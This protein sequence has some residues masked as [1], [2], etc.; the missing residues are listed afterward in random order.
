MVERCVL[1]VGAVMTTVFASPD[2]FYFLDSIVLGVLKN[3]WMSLPYMSLYV[4]LKGLVLAALYSAHKIRDVSVV[5]V[6][7]F[8]GFW[9]RLKIF[10]THRTWVGS[11]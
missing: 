11:L 7:M 5:E 1:I 6:Q 4:E 8:V 3:R 10:I 2:G 9:F